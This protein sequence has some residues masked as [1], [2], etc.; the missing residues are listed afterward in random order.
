MLTESVYLS[1]FSVASLDGRI[2]WEES[3]RKM[4]VC[5]KKYDDNGVFSDLHIVFCLKKVNI[6]DPSYA[7]TQPVFAQGRCL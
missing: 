2:K 7:P 5:S 3:I 6:N 4:W 1:F